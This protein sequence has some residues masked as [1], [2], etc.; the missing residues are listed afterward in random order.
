[1]GDQGA[2]N[3]LSFNMVPCF[4]LHRQP[5]GVATDTVRSTTVVAL[6]YTW[7]GV[8]YDVDYNIKPIQYGFEIRYHTLKLS[9]IFFWHK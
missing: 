4:F 9:F 1:M 6:L 7:C 8:L 3:V 2:R 5:S